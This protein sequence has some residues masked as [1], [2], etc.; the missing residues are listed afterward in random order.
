MPLYICECNPVQITLG[1][2][3]GKHSCK[4]DK[5]PIFIAVEMP[6]DTHRQ[7]PQVQDGRCRCSWRLGRLRCY[8]GFWRWQRCRCGRRRMCGYCCWGRLSCLSCCYRTTGGENNGGYGQTEHYDNVILVCP[9]V[10]S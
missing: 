8:R 9:F 10:R 2:C 7:W 3:P 4:A 6:D 1:V 5:G